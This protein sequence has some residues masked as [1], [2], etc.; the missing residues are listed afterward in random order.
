MSTQQSAQERAK[1]WNI[2]QGYTSE[3][4]HKDTIPAFIAGE[5]S[6]ERITLERLAA[7]ASECFLTWC[8]ENDR[9]PTRLKRLLW[10]E[11]R[12]PLLAELE[13]KGVACAKHDLTTFITC[14]HC[15]GER[16]TDLEAQNKKL[17]DVVLEMAAALKKH[18]DVSYCP[19]LIKQLKQER[20][21]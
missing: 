20:S 14:G 13:K 11:G 6:G 8:F 10:E 3:Q 1:K 5:V 18:C 12:L 17:G 4:Y 19:E 9:S 21:E 16:I 7:K 15:S 2:E